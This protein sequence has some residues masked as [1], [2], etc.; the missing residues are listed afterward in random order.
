MYWSAVREEVRTSMLGY[1]RLVDI[2]AVA[3]AVAADVE[4]TGRFVWRNGGCV[5][6]YIFLATDNCLI[7]ARG[8]SE[9]VFARVIGKAVRIG[10]K[11]IYF[12]ELKRNEQN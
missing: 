4:C 11:S 5:P 3:I 8:D 2:V 6:L 9:C 10:C 7:H 12:L 1:C